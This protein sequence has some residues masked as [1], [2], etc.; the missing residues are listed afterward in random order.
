MQK[1]PPT[2]SH[3]DMLTLALE[4]IIAMSLRK[5]ETQEFCKHASQGR[6]STGCQLQMSDVYFKQPHTKASMLI[7]RAG[8]AIA[9]SKH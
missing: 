8:G 1:Q 9:I 7:W 3:T 5:Q 6:K 2:N 4:P